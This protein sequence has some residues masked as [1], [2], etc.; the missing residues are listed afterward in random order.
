MPPLPSRAI[1]SP[2]RESIA[3]L[4]PTTTCGEHQRGHRVLGERNRR[5]QKP[6]KDRDRGDRGRER[7]RAEA[8]TP[9]AERLS[10]A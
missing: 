6:R 10:S 2:L 7:G 3:L 8:L 5:R 1:D 9:R 4:G